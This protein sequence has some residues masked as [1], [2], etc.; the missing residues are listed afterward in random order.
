M[1]NQANTK[2][3]LPAISGYSNKETGPSSHQSH[4]YLFPSS[5]AAQNNRRIVLA[6]DTEVGRFTIVKHI[7][8]GNT[9]DIYLARDNVSCKNVAVKIIDAGPC[10]LGDYGQ[11]LKNE[12]LLYDKISDHR[13]II[14]V[15]DVHSVKWAGTTLII[16]SME[17][18]DG[19][20]LKQY[21]EETDAGTDNNNI[22]WLESFRQFSLAVSAL[23]EAGVHHRD[24]KPDNFVMAGGIWKLCDLGNGSMV[25]NCSR[26]DQ[27]CDISRLGT[28]LQK[29]IAKYGENLGIDLSYS[30]DSR[31]TLIE[32]QQSISEII[33]K[34]HH[35]N[36]RGKYESVK[37]LLK[38]IDMVINR[39]VPETF[40]NVNHL[41]GRACFFVEYGKFDKAITVCRD[42]LQNTPSYNQAAAMLSH[43]VSRKTE[44]ERILT[45]VCDNRTQLT[46]DQIRELL[47]RAN[48]IYPNQ[49]TRQRI[50]S[51][52]NSETNLYQKMMDKGKTA[53]FSGSW[54]KAIVCF[55]NAV[56]LDCRSQQ[57]R[58]AVEQ[59]TSILEQI[60]SANQQKNQAMIN[61]DSPGALIIDRAIN[62]YLENIKTSMYLT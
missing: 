38:D 3:T 16:L 10:C 12:K 20:T 4:E 28:I 48:S 32:I 43:L 39:S 47:R 19:M 7:N 36:S 27:G 33:H 29:I 1:I 59:I 37:D 35:K 5:P 45:F 42:I 62:E 21:L 2:P 40:D 18:A 22:N 14:K 50:I 30:I 61:G 49:Q 9:A 54:E 13:H 31:D 11:L 24:I 41:W 25:S 15:Y 26:I 53:V 17:F 55:E 44:A 56:E 51:E 46:P 8:S 58:R 23:H 52:M 57:A 34:C 6:P 60:Q